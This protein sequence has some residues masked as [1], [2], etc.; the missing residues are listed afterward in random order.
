MEPGED[1]SLLMKANVQLV[2]LLV[3]EFTDNIEKPTWQVWQTGAW[4]NV[5]TVLPKVKL[6]LRED[7]REAAN[8][9]TDD[10]WEGLCAYMVKRYPHKMWMEY[11]HRRIETGT[12]FEGQSMDNATALA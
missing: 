1:I 8:Q 5:L 2:Q 3:P 9:L 10:T 11:F 6:C 4:K 7:I 12:L